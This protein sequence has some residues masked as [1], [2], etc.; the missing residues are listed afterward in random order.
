MLKYHKPRLTLLN[1]NSRGNL[2]CTTGT[3]ASVDETCEQ[4]T[5]L[6]SHA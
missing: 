5:H 1:K 3:N 2:N 6:E 4:G